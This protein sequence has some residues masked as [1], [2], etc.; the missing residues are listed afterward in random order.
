MPITHTIDHQSRRMVTVAAG[1]ID[2]KD[3]ETHWRAE[4]A[5]GGEAYPELVDGSQATVAFGPPE[6]RRM[7]EMLRIAA[8]SGPLGPTAVVVHTDVGFGMIR[9]FGMLVE[10]FCL[11]RPFRDRQEAEAWLAHLA[12]PGNSWSSRPETTS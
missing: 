8:A 5:E 1:P 7:V 11:I 12:P 9:M 4:V 3:L 2:L 10:S 6:V